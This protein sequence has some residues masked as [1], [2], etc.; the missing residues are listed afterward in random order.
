VV[1][2]S[3]RDIGQR[4]LVGAETAPSSGTVSL[5]AL[6]ERRLLLRT[7]PVP[8]GASARLAP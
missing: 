1:P 5:E 6:S 3:L 8:R 4:W 7:P 2:G